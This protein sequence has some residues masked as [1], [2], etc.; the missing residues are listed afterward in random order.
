MEK[1]IEFLPALLIIFAGALV[2]WLGLSLDRRWRSEKGSRLKRDSG[3]AIFILGLLI[4]STGLTAYIG[5]SIV[6]GRE[7]ATS[8]QSAQ[9]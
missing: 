5:P 8:S 9:E 2:A 1:L 6:D 7:K 4:G 3:T